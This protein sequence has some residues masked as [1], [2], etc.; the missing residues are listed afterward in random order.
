MQDIG[1]VFAFCQPTEAVQMLMSAWAF[2][3]D[4]PPVIGLYYPA[5]G[6]PLMS[7][8]GP[9][10]PDVKFE[11]RF[12]GDVNKPYSNLILFFLRKYVH[13]L[14]SLLVEKTRLIKK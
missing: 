13:K 8:S 12:N 4:N 14:P 6:Q 2:I 5:G 7:A 1:D 10:P 3:K 9:N 11:R